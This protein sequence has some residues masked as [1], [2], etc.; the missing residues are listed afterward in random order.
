MAGGSVS[1][2]IA[3][4]LFGPICRRRVQ[5][6]PPWLSGN[7]R[8]KG[9]RFVCRRVRYRYRDRCRCR[10]IVESWSG[11]QRKA[12]RQSS[13]PRR[14]TTNATS[15]AHRYPFSP[16]ESRSLLGCFL[17]LFFERFSL[18]RA[19][20]CRRGARTGLLILGSRTHFQVINRLGCEFALLFKARNTFLFGF[21]NKLPDIHIVVTQSPLGPDFHSIIILTSLFARSM[22]LLRNGQIKEQTRSNGGSL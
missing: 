19:R 12:L 20:A 18:V 5:G 11:S 6:S 10:H 22:L 2:R 15:R 17:R 7:T 9:Q 21:P 4:S 16:Y 1:S 3:C 8:Y 13:S 14:L